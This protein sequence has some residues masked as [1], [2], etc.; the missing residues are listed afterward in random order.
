[1]GGRPSLPLV[2]STPPRLTQT[3]PAYTHTHCHHRLPRPVSTDLGRARSKP[4]FSQSPSL[5]TFEAQQSVFVPLKEHVCAA[6]HHHICSH[7]H[8]PRRFYHRHGPVRARV[9]DLQLRGGVLSH[10]KSVC[11]FARPGVGRVV[12]VVVV[13]VVG[14]KMYEGWQR[15]SAFLGLL[16]KNDLRLSATNQQMPKYKRIF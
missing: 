3:P 1:M 12:V 4:W 2:S 11:V 10:Q 9:G 16:P 15:S 7:H 6:R 5:L 14:R 8:T 13:V